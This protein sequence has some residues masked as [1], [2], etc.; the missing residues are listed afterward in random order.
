MAEE[1]P[2]RAWWDHS[3]VTLAVVIGLA[4]LAMVVVYVL[5]RPGPPTVHANDLLGVDWSDRAAFRAM[6]DE[7]PGTIRVVGEAGEA[8]LTEGRPWGYVAI[9]NE[10]RTQALRC[11]VTDDPTRVN[12]LRGSIVEFESTLIDDLTDVPDAVLLIL[13]MR[14]ELRE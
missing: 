11:V 1:R 14:C 6:L 12:G 5:T 9:I 2:R 10:D 4:V 13:D 8:G 3:L 7:H